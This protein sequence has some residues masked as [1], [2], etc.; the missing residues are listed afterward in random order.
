MTRSTLQHNVIIGEECDIK[1]SVCLFTPL[2]AYSSLTSHSTHYM[3]F[4]RRFYWSH[5]LTWFLSCRASQQQGSVD[6]PDL[7]WPSYTQTP[8]H[9]NN[10]LSFTTL[11]I[12][13]SLCV[14]GI[15]IYSVSQSNRPL[16]L[17]WRNFINSQHSLIISGR[18]R[19]YTILNLPL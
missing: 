13:W 14:T 10:V 8:Q 12:Q 5:D 6:Q 1:A 18:E 11:L 19:P 9:H 16:W 7:W 15:I 17:I 4:C 3:S 2:V